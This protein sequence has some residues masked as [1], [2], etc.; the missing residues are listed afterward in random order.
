MARTDYSVVIASRALESETDLYRVTYDSLLN[1]TIRPKNIYVNLYYDEKSPYEPKEINFLNLGKEYGTSKTDFV[2][3]YD[4]WN[5]GNSKIKDQH[6]IISGD[7]CYYPPNYF[8]ILLQFID[9]HPEVGIT[10]GL[11]SEKGHNEVERAV[12]PSGSGRLYTKQFVDKFF[13]MPK[14]NCSETLLM[15]ENELYLR[16]TNTVCHNVSFVHNRPSK[17]DSIISSGRCS[18][19]LNYPFWNTCA[20]VAVWYMTEKQFR[21]WLIYGHLSAWCNHVPKIDLE[22]QQYIRRSLSEK[23]KTI[24]SFLVHHY[25]QKLGLTKKQT[26]PPPEQLNKS[27]RT[28]NQVAV[29]TIQ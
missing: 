12:L 18:Y 14:L 10:G 21:P 29:E 17:R 27:E 13:P 11:K 26:V 16:K 9:E 7:D 5:L 2:K 28:S 3:V 20:R 19:E 25:L 6:I 22:M 24:F 8:E 4:K 23:H 15:Y 1:Q